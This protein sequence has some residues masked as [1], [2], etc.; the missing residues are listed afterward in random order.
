MSEF[1][2]SREETEEIDAKVGRIHSQFRA[3]E[4]EMTT[5]L[6]RV[7]EM[8]HQV[9]AYHDALNNVLSMFINVR[10]T[11]YHCVDKGLKALALH[12]ELPTGM[13]LTPLIDEMEVKNGR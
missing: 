11:D 1:E 5:L 8:E 13:D 2:L 4:D 10:G 3:I 6:E 12:P 9:K 7:K